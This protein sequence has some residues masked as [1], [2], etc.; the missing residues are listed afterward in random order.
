[1]S[2]FERFESNVRSYCRAFPTTFE[3]AN[4]EFLFSEDGR[5]Y[6]DFFCGA[7]ALNYGHNNKHI[8]SA[9]IEYL[10]RDGVL[11]ALDMH[12]TAKRE[13]IDAFVQRCLK[14]KGLDYKLQFCGPTGTN[15][16]EAALKIAR[17]VTGRSGI[18]SFTGGFHGMSLGALAATSNRTSRGGA[19][20]AL[21]L[22]SFMPYPEG[23]RA[24]IDSMAYI[25]AVLED[26]HSG[27][28]KPAAI[29]V[30]TVQAEG[31]VNVAPVD[32][33]RQLAQLCRQH[34]ILLICDEIQVGCFRTGPFFSF[35]RAGIVPDIVVLAKSISGIGFPMSF[36][37][38]RP[39]L[40]VWRPGE[41][42][43]TFRGNQIAFVAGRAALEFAQATDLA[44]E[45][46]K[47]E[48]VI[49]E[50]LTS[51]IAPIND[52]IRIRG[53]GMIWG[54]DLSALAPT[55]LANRVSADCFARGLIIETVGRGDTVLKLLPPLTI[56][57]NRLLE[58]CSILRE[59]IAHF[60]RG[61]VARQACS[62]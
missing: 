28:E 14:P 62:E 43:G 52:K 26:S 23:F 7:G 13:F 6:I 59:S 31:G 56:D 55:D 36:V 18:F 41:H 8:K 58:G 19:G 51:E 17:K 40:D 61:E 39:E 47:R 48:S 30:E 3:S 10:S 16:V 60:A 57:M 5:R 53:I 33:L 15:A 1:M 38:L 49:K 2:I 45:V 4:D 46:K 22:V 42:T 12:T 54:V 25:E 29:I 24:P 37:L 44:G 20:A 32:W 35:E 34:G 11:H 50:F 21:P 9:V 27:V